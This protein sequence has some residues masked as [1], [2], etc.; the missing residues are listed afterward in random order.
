MGIN[1]D[2]KCSQEVLFIARWG[3]MNHKKWKK[4]LEHG[5]AINGFPTKGN[6]FPIL[7]QLFN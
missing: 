5:Y 4:G 3:E 6:E 7:K 1:A 2:F